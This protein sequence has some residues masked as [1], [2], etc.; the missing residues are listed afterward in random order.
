MGEKDIKADHHFGTVT[1]HGKTFNCERDFTDHLKLHSSPCPKC[2]RV[3]K[4]KYYLKE[5]IKAVHEGVKRYKCSKCQKKYSK[6]SDLQRHQRKDCLLKT[7]IIRPH[8]SEKV[9]HCL[10][11]CRFFKSKTNLE[12]HLKIHTKFV[13]FKCP[14]CITLYQFDYFQLIS[15]LESHS[16]Y[17][18][19]K[20]YECLHCSIIFRG[21]SELTQ[22]LSAPD[23]NIREVGE[24]DAK[25]D[26]EK[27]P[28]DCPV[29]R[30]S[31][32]CKSSLS[33]HWKELHENTYD[34]CLV[35]K[36]VFRL[37]RDFYSHLETTVCGKVTLKC[38]V[39]DV[40]YVYK[41]SPE[42][43]QTHT[44]EIETSKTPFSIKGPKN[45]SHLEENVTSQRRDAE[46]EQE[47]EFKCS[48]C[49]NSFVGGIFLCSKHLA[50][51][52][53]PGRNK[54]IPVTLETHSAG[55]GL[56]APKLHFSETPFVIDIKTEEEDNY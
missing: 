49:S 48:V 45:F 18:K 7:D 12:I 1:L 9:F 36:E 47:N 44:K 50:K 42:H 35:C 11:C 53:Q 40:A 41:N 38:L 23:A 28:F 51:Q 5:H 31:F 17:I 22:H 2:G 56:K 14:I 3:F 39:C 34:K 13:P 21:V 26:L 24:A 6:K 10:M 55:D 19:E 25:V 4:Q 27:A 54:D 52:F 33:I 32:P 8:V 46:E 16:D 29:C 37:G 43:L 15:H 30:L 20:Q